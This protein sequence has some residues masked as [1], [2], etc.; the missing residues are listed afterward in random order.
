MG[1]DFTDCALALG[2]N[3]GDRLENLQRAVAL[4]ELESVEKAPVFETTPVGCA[5]G[6][7]PFLN[8]VIVASTDQ[9]P[10]E[11]LASAQSIERELGRPSIHGTNE[12]RTID[13]DILYYGSLIYLAPELTLPHPRLFQRRFVLEPLSLLR[14]DLHLPGRSRTIREELEALDSDEPPLQKMAQAW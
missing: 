8:S 9:S 13:I 4:L 2:S 3:L 6:M 12:P 10:E 11:L 5:P 14:P 1:D 7:Q